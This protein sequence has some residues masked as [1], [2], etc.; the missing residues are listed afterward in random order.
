MDPAKTNQNLEPTLQENLRYASHKLRYF[1]WALDPPP[2]THTLWMIHQVS[3]WILEL[4]PPI[5]RE[6][7]WRNNVRARQ[8]E[9]TGWRFGFENR[10]KKNKK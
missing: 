8:N 1:G 7:V 2:H 3:L 6:A 9:G 10:K 5:T 4:E